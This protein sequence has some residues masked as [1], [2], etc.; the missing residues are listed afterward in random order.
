[1]VQV[2]FSKLEPITMCP[3]LMEEGKDVTISNPENTTS[4]AM[5]NQNQN[6]VLT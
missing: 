3:I 4:Q 1:M 6:M 2:L 5:I